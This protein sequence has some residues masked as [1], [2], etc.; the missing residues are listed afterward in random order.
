MVLHIGGSNSSKLWPADRY[1]ELCDVLHARFGLRS[2][3]LGSAAERPAASRIAA[4]CHTDPPENLAGTLSLPEVADLCAK[5]A[6][7]IGPDSALAHLADAAGT[8]SVVLFGSGD[9]AK[10]G[11]VHGIAVP[12]PAPCAPCSRFGTLHR[13]RGCRYECIRDIPVAAVLAAAETALHNYKDLA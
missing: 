10:W 1:A 9:P 5:A 13:R 2:I 4:L 11:P 12:S 7:F 8:P 3:L 6:L